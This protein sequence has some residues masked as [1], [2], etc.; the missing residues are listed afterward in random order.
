MRGVVGGLGSPFSLGGFF[1]LGSSFALGEQLAGV[2]VAGRVELELSAW[3][4]PCDHG[5]KVMG[6]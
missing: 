3:V 5:M 1:S 4:L 6:G 2:Y